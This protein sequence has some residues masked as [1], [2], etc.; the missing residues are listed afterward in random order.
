MTTKPTKELVEDAIAMVHR[1]Y[2]DLDDL[3]NELYIIRM[4]LK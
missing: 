4:R 3:R 2:K 1:L